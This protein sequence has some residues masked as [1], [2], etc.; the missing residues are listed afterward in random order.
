MA[1]VYLSAVL[2]FDQDREARTKFAIRVVA[3]LLAIGFMA[4]GKEPVVIGAALVGL[5]II[6]DFLQ[7]IGVTDFKPRKFLTFASYAGAAA[8]I[9]L[10]AA[11][12]SA[13]EWPLKLQG[14]VLSGVAACAS[15]LCVGLWW[16]YRA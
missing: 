8:L 5:V 14:L 16:K 3:V 10:I 2:K 6:L 12:V 1:L 7:E 13:V 4:T 11:L 15:L 9:S